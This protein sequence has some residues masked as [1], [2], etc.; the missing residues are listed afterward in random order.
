MFAAGSGECFGFD[1]QLDGGEGHGDADF[2]VE[3]AGTPETRVT[4]CVG[5]DAA[6]HG[7][8]RAECPDGVEVAEEQDAQGGIARAEAEFEDVTEVAVAVALDA[9]SKG[10]RVCGGEVHAGIDGGFGIGGGFAEDE[11]PGEVEQ[12]G[13]LAAGAG[14]QSAH[15]D[16]SHA[17]TVAY[18]VQAMP[19]AL[20]R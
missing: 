11:P 6:G 16:G 9:T 15:G 2:H 4:L 14:E 5:G 13:L 7:F 8:E 10:F 3:R 19:D 20:R 17:D 1:K 18:L 12:V